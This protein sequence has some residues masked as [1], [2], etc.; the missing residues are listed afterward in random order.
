[1]NGSVVIEVGGDKRRSATGAS[2]NVIRRVVRGEIMGALK[3]KCG[4]AAAINGI[5]VE[6]F[7]KWMH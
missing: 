2:E 4:K 5:V 3:M 7:E 1:M 6:I